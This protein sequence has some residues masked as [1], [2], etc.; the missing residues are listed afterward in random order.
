MWKVAFLLALSILVHVY[1]TLLDTCEGQVSNFERLKRRK[2][3]EISLTNQC[4]CFTGV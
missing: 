3:Y 4:Y 1:N 2:F